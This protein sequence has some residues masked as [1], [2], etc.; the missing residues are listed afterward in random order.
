MPAAAAAAATASSPAPVTAAAAHV[1]AEPPISRRQLRRLRRLERGRRRG[2]GGGWFFSL[3]AFALLV[4]AMALTLLT[5]LDVPKALS[6]GLPDP[7]AAYTLNNEIFPGY[8]EWP[9]LLRRIAI[10]VTGLL[11]ILA[12]AACALARRRAGVAHVVRGMLGIGMLLFSVALLG[13]AFARDGWAP[14]AQ[15]VERQ[16]FAAALAAFFDGFDSRVI[17]LSAAAFI[18]AIVLIVSPAVRRTPPT[19]SESKGAA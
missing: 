5:A 18:I 8:P 19:P 9:A 10:L 12:L 1:A 15:L 4:P 2:A 7:Q 17:L 16:H 6:V 11:T 14:I 3:V 13:A